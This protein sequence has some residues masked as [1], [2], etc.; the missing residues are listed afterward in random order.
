MAI[1]LVITYKTAAWVRAFVFSDYDR[2]DSRVFAGVALD[3]SVGIARKIAIS[4]GSD[5]PA[6]S[7][8]GKQLANGGFQD[9]AANGST[10]RRSARR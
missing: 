9:N 2:Y 3:L 5:Q 4:D 10:A 7:P 6:W 1:G 8:D